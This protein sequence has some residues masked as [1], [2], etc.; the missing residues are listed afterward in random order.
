MLSYI[1]NKALFIPIIWVVPLYLGLTL[2]NP[3]SWY[4]VYLQEDGV[5]EYLS[6]FFLALAA[7]MALKTV[8]K[9]KTTLQKTSLTLA[10]IAFVVCAGEEISWGQRLLDLPTPTWLSAHNM[11]N[12][13]TFHNLAIADGVSF[14]KF[15]A[16]II[17]P[18]ILL[19]FLLMPLLYRKHKVIRDICNKTALPVP[20]LPYG[21][22]MFTYLIFIFGINLFTTQQVAR[23]GE[24]SELTYYFFMMLLILKPHNTPE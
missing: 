5:V 19:Y 17:G 8:F 22:F 7:I 12:E 11:Q 18:L 3:S 4:D 21:I 9:A 14:N 2:S 20:Y 23:I 24:L 1:K 10:F 16:R 15:F 6:V 13:I